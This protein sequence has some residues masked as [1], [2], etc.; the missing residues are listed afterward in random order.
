METGQS[1]WDR[2]ILTLLIIDGAAVGI[3]SVFFLPLWIGGVVFPVSALIAGVVNVGLVRI[4]ALHADSTVVVAAPLIAWAGVFLVFALGSFGGSAAVP[5]D[6]RAALLVAVGALPAVM[7][8][9]NSSMSRAV[10]R[11]S[12][13]HRA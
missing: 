6:W 11:G 1:V 7:W 2:L 10:Q 8:L 4:A 13:A 3:L 9:S 5:V 12:L